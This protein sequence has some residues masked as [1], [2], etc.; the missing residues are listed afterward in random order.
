LEELF[1]VSGEEV[2]RAGVDKNLATTYLNQAFKERDDCCDVDFEFL[3]NV[4]PH[5]I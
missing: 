3:F 5:L 2:A 1:D 4:T